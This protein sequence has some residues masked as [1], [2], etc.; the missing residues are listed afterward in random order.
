MDDL[1]RTLIIGA[2]ATLVMDL[3]GV[4][5]KFLL[6]IPPPDYGLV[7]RWLA[8]MALSGRFRHDRSRRWVRR[9]WSVSAP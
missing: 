8:H 3:S 7:G 4:A 6:G 9:C 2:G 5:R 1:T